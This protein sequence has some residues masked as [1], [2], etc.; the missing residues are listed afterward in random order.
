VALA[1]AIQSLKAESIRDASPTFAPL[2]ATLQAGEQVIAL[3]QGWVKGSPC[4]V[5][6]TDRRLILVVGRSPQPLVQSLNLYG[7][8]ILLSSPDAD[9]LCNLK[10]IDGP[11][12]LQVRGVRDVLHAQKL[13]Q[14]SAPQQGATPQKGPGAQQP[15]AGDPRDQGFF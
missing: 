15:H 7:V 9:G 11:K 8:E 4:V 2:L 13:K 1:T 6:R 3:V 14:A 5:A 10:L 12:M